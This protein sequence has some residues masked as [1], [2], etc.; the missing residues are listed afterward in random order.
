[1]RAIRVLLLNPP[2]KTQN[3]IGTVLGL[4][5]PPLGLLYIAAVLERE[6]HEVRVLDADLMGFTV[7]QTVDEA[8]RLHPEVVGLSATTP[9]IKTALRLFAEIR[10]R[11]S[12]VVTIVGGVHPTF[13]PEDTLR[14]C[15][16]LDLVA[17][18]E[19]EET[20]VELLEALKGF[21]WG[22]PLSPDDGSVRSVQAL[23]FA[24][25]ISP[26]KGIA[27]RDPAD[28]E[29]IR[30]T[31]TRALIEN[32]DKIPPP[33]R[34]LVPFE[35]YMIRGKATKV[36][37][38][39]TSRGCPFGCTFCS[40]SRIAGGRFR[41]RTPENVVDEV[42]MLHVEYG[43][44]H[45][46]VVDDT[47]TLNQKRAFE[48]A[49]GL[50]DRRLDVEWYASSAVSTISRELIHMLARSGLS[51]MYFGVESGSQRILNLMR[52]QITLAQ[53]RKAFELCRETGV[54][55]L[56][57]FIVGYPGE[58]LTEARETIDF[59]ME[60][61]PDYAQFTVLTPYPGTPVYSELKAKNLLTTEDWDKYTSL[62]PVIKYEALGYSRRRVVST[63][64]DAYRR[65][66][67]RPKYLAKRVMLIPV[68]FRSILISSLLCFMRGVFSI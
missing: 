62:E 63:L 24:R 67:L 37:T 35:R 27:Y 53:V 66:Y 44:D 29:R 20:S 25:R 17:V 43:L 8:C 48:V 47:F 56:G 5:S 30:M 55:T 50:L 22:D 10:R 58:T 64:W 16:Q 68:I 45:V 7:K 59:A 23:E 13:L 21:Q 46:E 39:L 6:G 11:M 32:L 28:P 60:L 1:M 54:K 14:A 49:R 34:H 33:A 4:K 61:N 15:P 2:Q 51:T 52:K 9:T 19:A 36:G 40:S 18:G 3:R 31:Q 41:A 38:I 65:F 12:N 26:V 42:E 57:S